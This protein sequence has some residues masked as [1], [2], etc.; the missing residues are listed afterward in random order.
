MI[1]THSIPAARPDDIIAWADSSGL[2]VDGHSFDSTRTPQLIEP[3][4]AMAD[5]D[6]RIGTLIKPV[7]IGGSTAGEVV[8]AYW[9]AWFHGLIQY[10]WQDDQKAKDRWLDR[11]KKT[12]ESCH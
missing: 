3:M 5:A 2:K 11:I 4:R 10:N 12:L 8:A 6:T 1:F 7:Q 9:A